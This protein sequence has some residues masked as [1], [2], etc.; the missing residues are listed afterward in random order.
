MPAQIEQEVSR[1]L[2]WVLSSLRTPRHCVVQLELSRVVTETQQSQRVTK[3]KRIPV[4]PWQ[5]LIELLVIWML[6]SF[7]PRYHF[8]V[9]SVCACVL[10]KWA[11]LMNLKNQ[12]QMGRPERTVNIFWKQ[13]TELRVLWGMEMGN[14]DMKC[15]QYGLNQVNLILPW[16]CN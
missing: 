2:P 16:L 12:L 13:N 7:F 3:L 6:K 14:G 1:N 11:G 9:M 4:V 8:L 15:E 10:H 5:L